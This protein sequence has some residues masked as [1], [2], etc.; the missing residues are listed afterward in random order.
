[1]RKETQRVEGIVNHSKAILLS[2]DTFVLC[3]NEM[4]KI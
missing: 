4:S 2:L 1:M 3:L